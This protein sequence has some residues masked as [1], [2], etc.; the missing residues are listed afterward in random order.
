VRPLSQAD[1]D[2]MPFLA[3]ALEIWGLEL[4]LR[5]RVLAR[6]EEA[7]RTYLANALPRFRTWSARLGFSGLED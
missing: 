3:V 5:R 7:V 2:A 6:G 4:D 1:L